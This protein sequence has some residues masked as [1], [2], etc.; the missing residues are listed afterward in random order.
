MMASRKANNILYIHNY[1]LLNFMFYYKE[2]MELT[3]L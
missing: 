1:V 3:G 2:K